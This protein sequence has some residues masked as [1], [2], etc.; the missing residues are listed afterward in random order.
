M[1]ICIGQGGLHLYRPSRGQHQVLPVS[2]SGM[3]GF[4]LFYYRLSY[5]ISH[6]LFD[7]S[8]LLPKTVNV[9]RKIRI[10][11]NK[12]LDIRMNAN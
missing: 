10:E 6:F 3:S 4:F 5:Q 9:N 1:A 12:T 2:Y 11:A 8:I 7:K